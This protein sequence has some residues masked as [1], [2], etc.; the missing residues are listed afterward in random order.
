LADITLPKI[1][2]VDGRLIDERNRRQFNGIREK[3]MRIAVVSDIH[4]NFEAFVRCLKDIE[5]SSIDRIVN[6]G[7]AIGYGPQPEEV[8][9]LLE[10]RGI[11]NILGNHELAAIDKNFRNNISLLARR[12]LE[13]TMKFLTSASLSYIKKLPT[14]RE[15][16]GALMVHGC[17]PDS[18]TIYLSHMSLSEIK[19]TFE[20]NRF[21]IAFAGHTHH[22]MLIRYDG[23][24]IKFDLLHQN[25]IKLKPVYRYIVNVGTGSQPR[26]GDPR[27]KY[28]IWDNRRNTLEIRRIAYDMDRTAN[29]IMKRGF[30][31]RDM[32]RLYGGLPRTI[33]HLSSG[34]EL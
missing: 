26:D 24:D 15:V 4:G 18:P 5:R 6:L 13:Q 28:V 22:L 2:E 16:E 11:P 29:L 25:I 10:K 14:H 12:S 21:N 33:Q 31:R 7:D 23:K 27:A 20:S 1:V 30:L 34:V 32:E 19:E 17:P 8:L 3:T 9:C